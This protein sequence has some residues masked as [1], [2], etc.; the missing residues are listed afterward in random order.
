VITGDQTVLGAGGWQHDR[1]RG[2]DPFSVAQ[3]AATALA[4]RT[5][6]ANHHVAVVLGSGWADAAARLG[7]GPELKTT[8]LAG[9]P[10]FTAGGHTPVVRSVGAG[11]PRALVFLGRSH[12]YEGHGPNT[13]VHAVRVAAAAGC[14]TVVVTNAA[15]SLRT[16]WAVGQPVLIAD[17][18]NLTGVSPLMG[19]VPPARYGRRHVDLTDAYSPR[20]RDIARSVDP[21]LA[22]GVYAGLMGPEFETP[23]EIT[24][25]GRMGADLVGQSTVLET[26]AARQIGAE[27]LGISLVTN[28]AAG[29]APGPIDAGDVMAA[30]AAA[31]DRVGAL[32]AGILERLAA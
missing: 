4:E 15:G 8:E 16:E 30:G 6:A 23:A 25:L 20:L 24:M 13:V 2:H 5:G 10:P 29:L 9:F 32:L 27:V 18:L 31:T 21:S 22:E 17:H 28:L 26:I 12:L 1:M 14:R 7:D 19:P 3:R 11:K